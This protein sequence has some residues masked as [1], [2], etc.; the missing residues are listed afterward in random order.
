MQQPEQKSTQRV[1]VRVTAEYLRWRGHYWNDGKG[2]PRE[3][4]LR[5]RYAL[6]QTLLPNTL[7]NH[8]SAGTTHSTPQ[9]TEEIVWIFARLAPKAFTAWKEEHQDGL[10]QLDLSG[11]ARRIF[12][13]ARRTQLP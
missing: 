1:P 12:I 2:H 4:D 9:E 13:V 8:R 10:P 6:E 5:D 3:P 11:D 7:K